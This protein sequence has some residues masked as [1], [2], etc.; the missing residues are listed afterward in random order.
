MLFPTLLA[1]ASLASL[2]QAGPI[3]LDKRQQNGS[4]TFGAGADLPNHRT[5]PDG[6]GGYK[7]VDPSYNGSSYTVPIV[8]S[9]P[10]G[11]D[12]KTWKGYTTENEPY[13]NAAKIIGNPSVNGTNT[14]MAWHGQPAGGLLEQNPIYKPASNF[15]FQSFSLALLQEEIELDLFHYLLAEFPLSEWEAIGLTEDDRTLT[16]HMANQEVGHALALTNILGVDKAQ[17]QCTYQY[18]F[19]TL[20][21]GIYFNAL[22]T[23]W[24]EAGVYG[25]LN[26]LDS[27]PSA[28]ILLQSITTEARQQMI[29]R[30]FAGLPATPEWFETGL[31]QAYAWTLLSPYILSCPPNNTRMEFWR[32]PL[33]NVTNAP[34]ALE[35]NPGINSNYTLGGGVVGRRIDL[36]WEPL[37]K[38]V[39]WD[40]SYKTESMAG[41]PKY[42]A[43]FDQLNVT[44]AELHGVDTQKRVAHAFVPNSTVYP[45]E[46]QIVNT[47]FVSLVDENLFVTAYNSTMLNNHTVAVGIYQAS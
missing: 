36:S 37:G 34:S 35:G 4:S 28:Q 13:I 9:I 41:E 25:F 44:Y 7:Q 26:Q 6:S 17:K 8:H 19:K 38:A 5:I 1:A 47:A 42:L 30:Q 14:T 20:K 2:A 33:L 3:A 32:F 10:E 46:P 12:P 29:F 18:P 31:P 43:F 21:E 11:V 27:R 23:R 40:N 39:G 24:G 15:D 22:L 45:T 16:Q